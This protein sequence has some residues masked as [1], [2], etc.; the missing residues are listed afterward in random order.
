[1]TICNKISLVYLC[2][3]TNTQYIVEFMPL[4]HNIYANMPRQYKMHKNSHIILYNLPIVSL[5]ILWYTIIT[6]GGTETPKP[7]RTLKNGGKKEMTKIIIKHTVGGLKINEML[8]NGYSKREALKRYRAAHGLTGKKCEI[9][10]AAKKGGKI[11][12]Y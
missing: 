1:M 8:F 12:N 6:T 3:F 4:I 2:I 7:L 10:D 11:Y 5:G 9:I